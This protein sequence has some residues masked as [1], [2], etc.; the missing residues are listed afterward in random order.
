MRTYLDALSDHPSTLIF[1]FVEVTDGD[2]RVCA[3]R[4]SHI[5]AEDERNFC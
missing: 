1:F 2:V 5:N 4:V 3:L